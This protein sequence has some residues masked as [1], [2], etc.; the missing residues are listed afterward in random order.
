MSAEF[1]QNAILKTFRSNATL[2]N[3]FSSALTGTASSV[4]AAVTGVGTLFTTELT[5]GR[6]IGNV[7]KGFRR[8]TAI[9]DALH[10]TVASAF[11]SD[12][13]GDA[14]RESHI[15]KGMTRNLDISKVGKAISVVFRAATDIPVEEGRAPVGMRVRAMYGFSVVA[16][17]FEPDDEKAE[18]RK[19][20]Y[21]KLLRDIVDNNMN[22]GEATIIGNT[23]VGDS[24]SVQHPDMES[25]YYLTMP[26]VCFKTETMGSR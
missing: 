23:S 25:L 20:E 21:D 22:F 4:G 6:Y 1:V 24:M 12:L 18:Q 19:S 8:I 15:Y 9:A 2:S 26:V 10:L 17:F 7:A 5:V 11:D 14:V 13:S 16:V 3:D